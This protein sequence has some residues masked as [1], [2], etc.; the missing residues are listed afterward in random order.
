MGV[1]VCAHTLPLHLFEHEG[2]A[3]KPERANVNSVQM[4]G[5]HIILF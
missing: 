5:A 1:S 4:L 3:F 2:K